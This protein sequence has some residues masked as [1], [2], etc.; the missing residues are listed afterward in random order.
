MQTATL[1]YKA[2]ATK[3]GYRRIEQAM[4]NM[5]RLY[6][7]AIRHRE[8][9]S[10]CHKGKFS[11]KRQ[12]AHL[13]ELRT[14]DPAYGSYARKLEHSVLK[15]VNTPTPSTSKSLSAA[16][17]ALSAHTGSIRWKSVS[18]MWRT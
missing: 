3:D 9:A 18:Q 8:A 14:H 17:P 6:N 7:A 15:R 11:L 5:G 1:R 16:G 4:L 12:T 13:T 10:G 2:T